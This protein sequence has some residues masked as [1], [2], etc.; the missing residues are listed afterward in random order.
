MVY[1]EDW[2][3]SFKEKIMKIIVYLISGLIILT[4][5]SCAPKPGT[6]E[7][8]LKIKKDQIEKVEK[9]WRNCR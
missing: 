6:P 9:G 5:S 1:A 4:I 7:A 3:F 2:L 8:D